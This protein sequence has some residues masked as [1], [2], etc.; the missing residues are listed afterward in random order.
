MKLASSIVT[1]HG[2]RTSHAAIVSRELG[3]PAVVGTEI[4]THVLKQGQTVTVSCV[5]G[6]Q[7][8]VY[9]GIV[10]C[11]GKTIALD[12]IPKT[13]TKIMLNMA[14]SGTAFKWW[15]LPCDG[16]G[17]ARME[18]I[19]NNHIQIHPMAL[20]RWKE[21]KSKQAKKQIAHLTRAWCNK[22]DFFID[23][24]AHGITKIAAVHYPNPVIVR[25]SD[26][27]TNE[28]AKLIRGEQFEPSEDNPMLGWRGRKPL[29]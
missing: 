21:V 8:F 26:F 17:L 19:I 9:E 12:Q 25:L 4:G 1:D 16:V 27:K 23:T 20:V 13:K 24:L 6:D 28:Y 5:E 15:Q 18:F 22:E 3:I 11:P 29:L 7:G 10:K 14:D 2:E